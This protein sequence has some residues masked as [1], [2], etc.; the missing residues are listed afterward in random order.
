M[1]FADKLACAEVVQAW[2]F[3]RD[4]G[5]WADLLDTFHPDGRIH[6][7]WFQGAFPD[8]VERCRQNYGGS[9]RAKHLL[10]PAR[11][12]VREA[13]ATSETNVAIL[14]RQTIEG[15]EVD[16]TSYA[17]F[18]DRLE[19]VDGRWRMVERACVYEQDRLDPVEPS[20]AVAALMAKAD[21]G[22]FPPP[23]RYMAYRIAASG[24][25]L[26]EPVH[27]D[28]RAETEALKARYAAWLDGL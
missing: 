1:D 14:V 9:S 16:L 2:G 25:D 24:R 27:H 8:F 13:R 4:Q 18:L 5:R 6:V 7:S 10:W 17:R 20:A 23:Y 26:A 21:A 3:A 19:R 12:Q 11:V 22:R 28:G 15:V